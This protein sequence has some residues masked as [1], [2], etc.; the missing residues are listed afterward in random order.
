MNQ[1]ASVAG[2]EVQELEVKTIPYWMLLLMLGI[3]QVTSV[4]EVFFTLKLVSLLGG[5]K[6]TSQSNILD[7]MN[8][9]KLYDLIQSSPG[10]YFNEIV[11]RTGLNRGTVRYHVDLLEAEHMIVCHKVKGKMRY[12][13]NSSTYDEKD[14]TVIAALRNDMTRQIILEIF[15]SERIN[16]ETLAKTIGIST[17][18]MSW[19]MKRL[20]E[21]GIVRADKDGR[22]ATYSIDPDYSD[23]VEGFLHLHLEQTESPDKE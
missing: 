7:N 12:F 8:R 23:S 18:S 21:L 3:T 20:V 6:R 15:N 1:G 10:A 13:Q 19:H 4:P 5:Y 22:Y 16:N 17:S 2:E 14:M 11:K 9:E